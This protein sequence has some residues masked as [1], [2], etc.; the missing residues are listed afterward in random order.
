MYLKN[1]WMAFSAL[2][3]ALCISLY[4]QSTD[5][6]GSFNWDQYKILNYNEDRSHSLE[7]L[8]KKI[9]PLRLED[10]IKE[11]SSKNQLAGVKT[12]VM[13]IGVG[14][15][16][17]LMTLKKQFPDVEFYGINKEK[18]HTFYRRESYILTALKFE[19]MTRQELEQI[20]LPYLI[21][22][23]LDFGFK[24]PYDDN[25][26]D[27]IFSQDTMRFIRYKFELWDEILRV[28]KPDGLSI[29]TDVSGINIYQEGVILNNRDAFG[30]M[31]RRGINISLLENPFSI[32]F[33]KAEAENL[34]FPVAP[35]FPIPENTE[36]LSEELKKPEMGY[37]LVQ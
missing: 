15:G 11:I 3:I 18:T 6:S 27:L 2:I 26:F 36:Q 24:I 12:R 32:L 37:N 20:E 5:T 22:T 19:I 23:D 13:E 33:K 31:K 16:R 10:I 7:D 4:F 35:H 8:N 21:F 17:V 9:A 1:A 25:K 28:L 34:K 30:D 14:N 29:H